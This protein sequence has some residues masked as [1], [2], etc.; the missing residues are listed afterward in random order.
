VGTKFIIDYGGVINGTLPLFMT[1]GMAS[2]VLKP[3]KTASK[4]YDIMVPYIVMTGT[5][6]NADPMGNNDV[7]APESVLSLVR[8]LY[9]TVPS[10]VDYDFG[11]NDNTYQTLDLTLDHTSYLYGPVVNDSIM[12]FNLVV[13]RCQGNFDVG[14]ALGNIHEEPYTLADYTYGCS[15]FDISDPWD[16]A[17]QQQVSSISSVIPFD[18][19]YISDQLTRILPVV[20]GNNLDSYIAMTGETTSLKLDI[21]YA[22]QIAISAAANVHRVAGIGNET[23]IADRSIV[24]RGGGGGVMDFLKKAGKIAVPA[25][26]LLLSG[27]ADSY[28]PGSGSLIRSM[29]DSVTG[30]FDQVPHNPSPFV[31]GLLKRGYE[32][33]YATILR[34]VSSVSSQSNNTLYHVTKKP[35]YF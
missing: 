17:A 5:K 19:N 25:I 34:P 2:L 4:T 6:T 7:V 14:V 16:D 29:G 18:P 33:P 13:G 23:S 35:V 20:F 27:V 10:T 30:L 9:Q 3:I 21:N 1:E 26:S 12:N 15:M 22:K 28:A 8:T 11:V 31:R 32:S 24:A